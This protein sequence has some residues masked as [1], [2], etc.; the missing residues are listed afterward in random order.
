MKSIK[1]WLYP[2]CGVVT[3]LALAL[4]LIF[5]ADLPVAYGISYGILLGVCSIWT[6]RLILHIA[7][8]NTPESFVASQ[9]WYGITIA[10]F[11]LLILNESQSIQTMLVFGIAAC[12]VNSLG[13]RFF[14][15]TKADVAVQAEVK[16]ETKKEVIERLASTLRY[17]YLPDNV[18]P[19]YDEPLCLYEGTAL[20]A[21]EA[22][23]KGLGA[24]Y[25]SAIEYIKSIV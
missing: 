19:N 7:I 24:M 11:V 4:P 5:A 25:A 14:S 22:E 17:R 8:K 1:Y 18:T 16:K 23:K 21:V 12:V 10:L 20:T 13:F 2:L 9:V 15:E 6:A 3:F